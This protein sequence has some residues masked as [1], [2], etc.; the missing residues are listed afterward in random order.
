MNVDTPTQRLEPVPVPAWSR[1]GASAITYALRSRAVP[2][3][4]LNACERLAEGAV[5]GISSQV[6]LLGRPLGVLTVDPLLTTSRA[7]PTLCT[8]IHGWVNF[9]MRPISS[10]STYYRISGSTQIQAV[11]LATLKQ[12]RPQATLACFEEPLGWG[13]GEGRK[14]FFHLPCY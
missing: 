13:V 1:E 11:W 14:V 9:G 2:P 6:G 4:V 8:C 10:R 5:A 12:N 3:W 7:G